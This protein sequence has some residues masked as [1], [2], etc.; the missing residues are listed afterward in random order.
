M[1]FIVFYWDDHFKVVHLFKRK[2]L[3]YSLNF[4]LYSFLIGWI[5]ETRLYM[6]HLLQPTIIRLTSF[7]KVKKRR[8]IKLKGTVFHNNMMKYTDFSYHFQSR[9]DWILDSCYWNSTGRRSVLQSICSCL[10]CCGALTFV[11]TSAIQIS[12]A[13][14]GQYIKI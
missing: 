7:L 8:Q 14:V 9:S 10:C 5:S 3:F 1:S 11:V 13:N 4:Q 6:F 2:V 12:P